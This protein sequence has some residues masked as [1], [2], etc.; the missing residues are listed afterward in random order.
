MY[1]SRRGLKH[2]MLPLRSSEA[3]SPLGQTCNMHDQIGTLIQRASQRPAIG[4]LVE[5][6]SA[7]FFAAALQRCIFAVGTGPVSRSMLSENPL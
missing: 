3:L 5:R 4:Q 2:Y 7:L 6:L 1:S